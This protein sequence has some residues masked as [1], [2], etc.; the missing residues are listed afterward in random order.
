MLYL[1]SLTIDKF[2]SFKHAEILVSK[3]FTC[4]VGPNG[5]GKSNI[6]DALLFGLGENS[7]NRLRVG[8]LD[9][10]ID[11]GLKR[12][13]S[14]V[15][16]A[17]VKL[18]LAG[19]QD[20]VIV[21]TVRS[22]GKTVYTVNGKHTTRQ[23]VLEILGVNRIRADETSTITQGEINRIISMSTKERRE[24]IDIASGIK[25][26]EAKKADALKELEKV[27]QRISE[28]QGML[29]EKVSFL[30]ELEKEKESAEKFTEYTAKLKTLK[31]SILVAR[32]DALKNSMDAFTKEMAVTDSKKNEAELRRSEIAK[33]LSDLETERDGITHHISTSSSAMSEINSKFEGVNKE[34]A[35]LEAEI[36]SH[37]SSLIEMGIFSEEAEKELAR[38]RE[39]LE[40]GSRLVSEIQQKLQTLEKDAGSSISTPE[41]VGNAEKEIDELNK[42]V[43]KLEKLAGESQSEALR[44][45]SER[46]MLEK[47]IE[48]LEV[49]EE[50]YKARIK[51][52]EEAA[53][54][55][56]KGIE[57]V[58][59]TIKKASEN[60]KN[61]ESELVKMEK[62]SDFIDEKLIEL[63]EQK[64]YISSKSNNLYEKVKA[65][66]G[67]SK[68]FHGSVS[69]LC[70]YEDKYA[71]AV[72]TAGGNRLDYFVTDSISSADKII[73]YLKQKELGRATFI[74]IKEIRVDEAREG[75]KGLTPVLDAIKYEKKYER[76]FKYIFNNSYIVKDIEEAKKYGIGKHR[77]VT[78]EG[79]LIEQSGTVAGG[80]AKRRVS[81]A[82]IENQIKSLTEQKAKLHT[83]KA[84]AQENAFAERKAQ[85]SAESKLDSDSRELSHHESEIVGMHKALDIVVSKVAEDTKRIAALKEK[86]A[87]AVKNHASAEQQLNASKE[88]LM[89]LYNEAVEATR[90]MAKHGQS[91]AEREKREKARKEVEELRI[92]AAETRKEAEMLESRKA[93]LEKQTEEKK[94]LAKSVN[95]SIKEKVKKIEFLDKDRKEA[96]FKIKNSGEIS[97][98]SMERL[99]KI[100]EEVE[101]LREDTGRVNMQLNEIDR[102][103][104][105]VRVKRSQTETRISDIGAELTAYGSGI[106]VVKGDIDIMVREA[107]VMDSKLKDLGTVNMKAPELYDEKKKSVDEALTKS[108]TLEVERQAVIRMIEEIDSKKLQVFMSTFNDV[109]KNFSKLYNYI[110][111]GKAF[112]ELENPGDPFNGGVEIK[113]TSDSNLHKA[114]RS[115]SGG[116]KSLI[117]LMMLFSI[118]LCKPSSIYVFDEVDSALDKENSKKLSQLI[119]EMSKEAQFVVVSHNDSLISNADTAVGVVMANGESKVVGLELSSVLKSSK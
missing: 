33:R 115:M 3:G 103:L 60:A 95:L 18:E 40:S 86:D 114:L 17:H 38:I 5:S 9:E 65:E 70:T 116:Q 93:E 54:K 50:E 90:E 68:G 48:D 89:R 106:P 98:K 13:H 36:S 27:S 21:R 47:A 8:R 94:K 80:Y 97:K 111:P 91:K 25:E 101:R 107:D 100:N 51:D 2:K 71:V 63:K 74:P 35:V 6:C 43:Q 104:G 29:N 46:S 81:L 88:R 113:I 57:S 12:K 20:Y 96:E 26:F 87:A 108:N 11:F 7:M 14:E 73:A 99:T 66:F 79:E 15:A 69:S 59:E 105:D 24:L 118:H 58:R 119:K 76:V 23:E 22:D 56:R 77:Y 30:R 49:S 61:G 82:S 45:E 52:A 32:K 112:I 44:I 117:L 1:K 4:V 83:D 85:A 10:L 28:T 42:S 19:D 39:T 78:L 55:A 41:G 109:N 62:E 34:I 67:E 37:K 53:V 75:E 16:K 72:E 110:F 92:K 102:N 64:S 84:K 31:Y